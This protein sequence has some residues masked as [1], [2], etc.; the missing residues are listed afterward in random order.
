MMLRS[1]SLDVIK[2]NGTDNEY[3]HRIS[4]TEEG[5]SEKSEIQDRF[6]FHRNALPGAPY[7]WAANC[8][9]TRWQ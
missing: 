8:W 9:R 4:K 6:R 3:R 2:G 7:P 5:V 1:G